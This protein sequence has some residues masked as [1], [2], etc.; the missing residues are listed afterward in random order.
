[1]RVAVTDWHGRVSP[2]FDVAEQV[3]LV[4][5]A[6]E[7]DGSQRTESLGSL[8]SH[9]R[10]R[11][12]AELGVNVLVCGAISWPLEALLAAKGIRVISLVCGDVEE[13]VKAF[14]N[15]TLEDEQFA[16]PGCCRS[17]RRGAVDQ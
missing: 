1:M 15:G 16:M 10:A 3:R 8:A 9:D 12:L 17:R 11:R 6:G 7:D 2:V 14:R 5:L 4:D 13:V